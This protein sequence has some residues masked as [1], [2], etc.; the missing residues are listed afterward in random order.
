VENKGYKKVFGKRKRKVTLRAPEFRARLNKRGEKGA[1]QEGHTGTSPGKVGVQAFVQV[2]VDGSRD[3]D[4]HG[5][6]GGGRT[7]GNNYCGP[8]KVKIQTGR[9]FRKRVEGFPEYQE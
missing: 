4:Q 7:E 3:K 8:Q 2:K 6:W 5:T 9:E 1:S